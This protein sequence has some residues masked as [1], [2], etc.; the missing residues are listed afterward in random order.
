MG[1]RGPI[2]FS[3]ASVIPS[4]TRHLPSVICL[5][6]NLFLSSSIQLFEQRELMAETPGSGSLTLSGHRAVMRS[7]ELDHVEF[8]IHPASA[9]A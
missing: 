6:V 7:S 9:F 1:P 8:C 4:A 5:R 3:L 2:V